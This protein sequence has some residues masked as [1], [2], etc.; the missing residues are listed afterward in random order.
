MFNNDDEQFLDRMAEFAHIHKYDMN[1]FLSEKENIYYMDEQD[2]AVF[3][4]QYTG[5]YCGHYFFK[6]RGRQ[7]INK[8]KFI[9]DNLFLRTP[10][11]AVMGLTPLDN[12]AAKWM[13]RQLDFISQGPIGDNELFVLNKE[14]FRS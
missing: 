9:L 13:N 10:V 12:K 4:H 1:K 11:K 5:L 6:S 14:H 3:V 7:A 8:G 2:I